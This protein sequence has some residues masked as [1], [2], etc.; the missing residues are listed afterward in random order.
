M[1]FPTHILLGIVLFLVIKDFFPGTNQ[2][3]AFILVLLGSVLPDID[4][5]RSKINRWSGILG[6]IVAFFSRHRGFF[7]SLVFHLIV[8]FTVN[9]FLGV[10][11]ASALLLGYFSHLI[12]DG[13]TPMGVQVLYP[14]FKFKLRG[15]IIVGGIAEKV[16]MIT[17]AGFVTAKLFV[18][19][20]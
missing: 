7:H 1:L 6:I 10:Y 4:E 15:P 16:I 18:L 20:F 12:G 2:I 14:F 5:G 3:I 17:L 11:Y 19:V 9:Y 13:I 8:F